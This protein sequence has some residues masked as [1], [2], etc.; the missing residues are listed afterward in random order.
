MIPAPS[1]RQVHFRWKRVEKR[2]ALLEIWLPGAGENRRFTPSFLQ[3]A[4]LVVE[5]AVI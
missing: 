3:A 5:K 4:R 2:A 1:A